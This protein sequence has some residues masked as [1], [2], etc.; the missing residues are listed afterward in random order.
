[1]DR[2]AETPPKQEHPAKP[3]ITRAQ[4]GV[5]LVLAAVQFT[6][7]V[8]FVIIMPLGD[9]LMADLGISP[10]G[11]SRVV[12]AYGLAAFFASLLAS[13]VTD[14][15]DRKSV[16]LGTYAGFAVSTFLCGLAA[17]PELLPVPAF[18]WLL[19]TRA[20]AGMFGGLAAA[21]I[22]AIIGDVFPAEHRGTAS[23]AVMSAFA[24]ASI[25]GLPIGL[26]LANRFGWGAPFLLLGGVSVAVWAVILGKL[27]SLRGHIVAGP[28][29][30]PGVMVASVL[31]EPNHLR[32]FAWTFALVLGTFTVIP[33][34]GPYMTANVGR[35]DEDLPI[36]YAVAGGCTLVSMNV[37]GR[38]ADRYGKRLVFRVMA[39]SAIVM[40]LGATNLPPVSLGL[41]VLTATGFMVCATGRMVPAQAMLIGVAAPA[42]RGAFLSVNTATQHLA[43]GVAPMI[44]GELLG[45]T[46]GGQLTNYHVVGYVAAGFGVLSL[47]L[48]EFVKPAA[49]SP[50][51]EAEV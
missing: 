5:V 32:A 23:G 41:A 9:R 47:V 14:R 27:P 39:V 16:L 38:L 2:A 25:A 28:R 33:F 20:L 44:S 11:F 8:D 21:A 36:I 10:A 13:S 26:T 22:M 19:I 51:A 30:R 49:V 29:A 50:P 3:R 40:V 1:M 4:W 12:S 48:S 31:E 24:V 45:K 42:V 15:F 6:H 35:S 18:E 46:D 7:I 43:T 17:F 34:L 37:L